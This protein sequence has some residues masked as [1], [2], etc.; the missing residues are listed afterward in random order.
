MPKRLQVYDEVMRQSQQEEGAFK[1]LSKI[2]HTDKRLG[3][4]DLIAEDEPLCYWPSEMDVPITYA[5]WFYHKSFEITMTRSVKN[6]LECYY[7]S[8]GNNATLLVNI[9]PKQKRRICLK[10]LSNGCKLHVSVLKMILQK[11]LIAGEIRLMS[12]HMN[13]ALIQAVFKKQF[14]VKILRIVREL[15]NLKL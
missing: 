11:G 1:M 7:T 6:L 5:G 14:C 15:K 13:C 4:R 12:T 8:V 2:D 3:D 9:P 10:S